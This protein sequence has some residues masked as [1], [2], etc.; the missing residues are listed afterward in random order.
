MSYHSP[1]RTPRP[2]PILA[3]LGLVLLVVACQDPAGIGRPMLPS[4]GGGMS[5]ERGPEMQSMYGDD[6]VFLLGGSL[7]RAGDRIGTA[8]SDLIASLRET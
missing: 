1:I 7:L 2:W 8:I 6:T 3:I 5:A 4:P